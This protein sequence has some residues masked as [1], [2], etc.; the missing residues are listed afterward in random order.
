M[1]MRLDRSDILSMLAAG[2]MIYVATECVIW[3][4]TG[5]GILYK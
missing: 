5:S 4:I 2:V 1:G 3:A